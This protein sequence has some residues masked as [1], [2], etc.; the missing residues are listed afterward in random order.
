MA[1]MS[2]RFGL[3]QGIS[4][5][6]YHRDI[7]TLSSSGA[8]KL[9]ELP[10][11]FDWQRR[12]PQPGSSVFDIGKLA[13]K[14]ILGEGAEVVVVDAP[15]WTTKAA[16][17]ARDEARAIGAIPCLISE[18][19]AAQQMRASVM[20]NRTAAGLLVDG[21]AEL[22]GYWR[23][24]PTDVGLR[25]RPDWL[26][27]RTV[28]ADL[29]TTVNADPSEFGKSVAKFGYHLQ[30]AWYLAGLEAHGMDDARLLFICVEKTAPYPVSVIELDDEAVS[31]GRRLMREAVDLFACCTETGQWPGY[32]DNITTIG[33]PLWALP[34]MEITI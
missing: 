24:E 18:F 16:R 4:D 22:S 8:R 1:T 23:D 2:E 5:N 19:D 29:K 12:N 27:G 33:L 14:L 32:D 7:S 34:D 28:C 3:L 31:E 11:R 26:T 13:H 21:E 17:E 25:F 15:N 30:A 10:A 9:L 20:A 6:E